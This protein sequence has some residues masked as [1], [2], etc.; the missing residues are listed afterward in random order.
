MKATALYW[1]T[2]AI[3]WLWGGLRFW[4]YLKRVDREQD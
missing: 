4:G 3:F 1:M 2:L